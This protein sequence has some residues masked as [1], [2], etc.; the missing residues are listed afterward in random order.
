MINYLKGDNQI[1]NWCNY[2]SDLS[3]KDK[4]NGHDKISY[5][6]LETYKLLHLK[7]EKYFQII[8]KKY[9]DKFN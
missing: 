6:L 8:K 2:L 9:E 1:G 3:V 4:I 7:K 5:F